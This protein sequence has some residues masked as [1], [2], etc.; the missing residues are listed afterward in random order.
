M[1]YYREKLENY[2]DILQSDCFF[3]NNFDM[4]ISWNKTKKKTKKIFKIFTAE[5]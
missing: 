4:L 1:N 3:L 5:Q 2:Y